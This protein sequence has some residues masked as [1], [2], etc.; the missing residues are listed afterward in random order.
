MRA[1]RLAMVRA[2]SWTPWSSLSPHRLV[3]GATGP[4]F[5]K[6]VGGGSGVGEQRISRCLIGSK[7]V[8]EL[9][10]IGAKLGKTRHQESVQAD[11]PRCGQRARLGRWFQFALQQ[12]GP[13]LN[14]HEL[15]LVTSSVFRDAL[16]GIVL[17]EVEADA[18]TTRPQTLKAP[19]PCL[20]RCQHFRRT[21]GVLLACRSLVGGVQFQFR[22]RRQRDCPEA[23]DRSWSLP[24][25]NR[26]LRK[27]RLRS[28]MNCQARF[29]GPPERKIGPD[30]SS[31]FA[32]RP[33]SSALR[34]RGTPP[35]WL[36]PCSQ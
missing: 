4:Y 9:V 19:M 34:R 8:L 21:Q 18:E 33:S 27:A 7:S 25:L 17:K 28:R 10:P 35:P 16:S 31:D 36:L 14:E 3:C 11:C 23:G 22:F 24:S 30:R 32:P 6:P 1:V 20:R 26:R 15:V 12:A 5:A 13:R 29:A 2:A